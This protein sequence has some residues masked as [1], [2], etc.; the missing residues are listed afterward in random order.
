MDPDLDLP[1]RD[2][3]LEYVMTVSRIGGGLVTREQ[4]EAFTFQGRRVP[5]IARQ[6]GIHKPSGLAAALSILT[7][8]SATREARPYED[9]IGPDGYQ[10]Q[11]RTSFV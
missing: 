6:R 2:Q 9:E 3:A 5:L 4:L 7:T 1:L 8:Y 10:R 11:S